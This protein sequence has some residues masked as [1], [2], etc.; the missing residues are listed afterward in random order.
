MC[1]QNIRVPAA[2]KL[3]FLELDNHLIRVALLDC[4]PK[5]APSN[6]SGSKMNISTNKSKNLQLFTCLSLG[7]SS[8]LTSS[9]TFFAWTPSSNTD[10]SF[11]FLLSSLVFFC[12]SLIS[13]FV[14]ATAG[15]GCDC[16]VFNVSFF[17]LIFVSNLAF[18]FLRR[19]FEVFLFSLSEFTFLFFKP[20]GDF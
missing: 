9:Q 3:L 14:I 10:P 17:N 16:P 20:L 7:Q 11:F 19:T 15:A 5:R 12:F 4:I 2:G 8:R 18:L 13:I 1:N 6:M